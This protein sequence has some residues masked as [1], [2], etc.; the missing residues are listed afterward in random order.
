M[1]IF[2]IIGI[3]LCGA[4][5]SLAVKQYRQE[6]AVC[7]GIITGLIILFSVSDGLGEIF[8]R[9]NIIIEKSGV[10]SKYLVAIL[11]IVGICLISQFS[12]EVCKDAGQ[13]AIAAKLEIAGKIL[14]LTLTIPIINDFMD[15]CINTVNILD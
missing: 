14:I 4:V 8:N 13:N 2:K 9:M 10:K 11:K 12:A 7:I 5:L 3:A 15:I 6:F 1:D